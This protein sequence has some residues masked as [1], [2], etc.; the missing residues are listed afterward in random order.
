MLVASVAKLLLP[1]PLLER[2]EATLAEWES[3]YPGTGQMQTAA[4]WLDH[5]SCKDSSPYCSGFKAQD[6]VQVFKT[7]HYSNYVLNPQNIELAGI[8][9]YYPLPKTGAEW[10]LK[11][12]YNS[13]KEAGAAPV[14]SQ[15]P[16]RTSKATGPTLR[17]SPFSL[18][19]HFRLLLHIFGDLH[20]PL[21]S[22]SLFAKDFPYGDRGGNDI[23]LRGVPHVENLHALWDSGGAVFKKPFF[24]HSWE[25]LEPIARELIEEYPREKFGERLQGRLFGMDFSA[26]AR[27]SAAIAESVAYSEFDWNTF[28]KESLPYE[29]SK[30]YIQT[31]QT[32]SREQIALG[33]YRLANLLNSIAN[34]FPPPNQQMQLSSPTHQQEEQQQE[35]RRSAFSFVTDLISSAFTSWNPRRPRSSDEDQHNENSEKIEPSKQEELT[36]TLKTNST[37]VGAV[38]TAEDGSQRHTLKAEG[39]RETSDASEV[40]L[41]EERQPLPTAPVEL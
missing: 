28:S 41:R 35:Q 38:Y 29:P 24:S 6:D 14:S 31:V 40:K 27:E 23:I 4:V 36:K 20:Q 37:N 10:A 3:E 30:E 9:N 11:T 13:L 25:E 21:H 16:R 39:E 22:C 12:I 17:G 18:N 1:Q 19:L 34:G 8:Y 5:L 33:G 15:S 7:W 26:I 2:I 32:I